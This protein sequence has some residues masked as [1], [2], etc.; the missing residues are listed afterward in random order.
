MDIFSEGASWRVG[1]RQAIDNRW[2]FLFLQGLNAIATYL[3]IFNRFTIVHSRICVNLIWGEILILQHEKITLPF[4]SITVKTKSK[5]I[6]QRIN[7][8]FSL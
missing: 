6:K 7:Y 4:S 8:A 2:F 5:N 3:N 1:I